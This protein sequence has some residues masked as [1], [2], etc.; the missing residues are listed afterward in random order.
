MLKSEVT[1]NVYSSIF[2]YT[3]KYKDD[4]LIN[5]KKAALTMGHAICIFEF[6]NKLWVY[7]MNNGTMYVG[8]AGN[9]NE[10]NK[11]MVKWVEKTYNISIEKSFVIDDWALPT[12]ITNY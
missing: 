10:Y 12:D 6:K 2:G 4:I 5:G 11:L 8:I 9:R 1:P 7:D 3:F